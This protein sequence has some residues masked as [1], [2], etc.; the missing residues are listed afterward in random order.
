MPGPTNDVHRRRW[1]CA[2]RNATSLWGTCMATR[3]SGTGHRR[4]LAPIGSLLAWMCVAA[5]ATSPWR[6]FTAFVP[7]SFGMSAYGNKVMKRRVTAAAHDDAVSTPT[8]LGL[9]PDGLASAVSPSSLETSMDWSLPMSSIAWPRGLVWL[10]SIVYTVKYLRRLIFGG[11]E[12]V[13]LD[14]TIPMAVRKELLLSRRDLRS[15]AK[16]APGSFRRMIKGAADTLEEVPALLV[17]V[18]VLVG[19]AL[20]ADG[21][22]TVKDEGLTPFRKLGEATALLFTAGRLH[23]GMGGDEETREEQQRSTLRLLG[24]DFLYAEGQWLLAELGCMPN[25]KLTARMIRNFSDGCSAGAPAFEEDSVGRSGDLG[26]ERSLPAAYL[27]T[28]TYFASVSSGSA[29]L[30]GAPPATVKAMHRY[31]ADLG[32]AIMIAQSDDANSQDCAMWLAQG[33]QE[34]LDRGLQDSPAKSALRRLAFRVERSCEK[35][36]QRL[37]RAEGHATRGISFAEFE[38]MQSS[39]DAYRPKFDESSPDPTDDAVGLGYQRDAAAEKELQ[40]LIA[41][42]LDDATGPP[43]PTDFSWPSEGPKKT[44]EG[45]LRC[46][47]REIMKVNAKLDGPM[48]AAPAESELVREEVCALFGAGGKRLRPALVLLVAQALKAPEEQLA[49]VI[50]LAVS[51]EV[52]HGASLIHDDI[53]DGSDMRRGSMTAHV[54]RGRKAAALAGDFLF[55]SASGLVAELNSLP[56][57]LLISKVVADFGRGELAQSAVKFET[58]RYSLTDYLAKSHYKT[59]SLLAAACQAA[60]VLSGEKPSSEVSNAAYRF[61][62]FIG[63]AFQV[64]D[65]VL[66]FTATEEELG[67]PALQDLAEGNLSAPV[68]YAAQPETSALSADERLELTEALGRRVAGEGDLDRVLELVEKADSIGQ[69]K[70]LARRYVDLAIAELEVL[71]DGEARQA[72][73]VFAEYVFARAY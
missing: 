26:L 19:D 66:D 31:G 53:L 55:A 69:T 14:P 58:V 33:A 7:Q 12:A 41:A 72:L 63:L 22:K 30:S 8:A 62:A 23:L 61:G 67:K 49:R 52:L 18:A 16:D 20:R 44:L 9:V 13:A 42:G 73:R 40:A 64:V 43:T 34:A 48:L 4:R 51:V 29:W 60:A 10:G 24:G 36:L 39:I 46:V 37:L 70:A 54:R 6:L 45:A 59:A 5:W 38:E 2:R 11:S 57:V 27:R 35:A 56:T 21:H 32:C 3:F 71:P 15:R 50:D 68:L 28:G 1:S 65:D 47:G 17:S 25:I